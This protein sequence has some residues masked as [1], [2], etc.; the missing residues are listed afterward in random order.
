MI[1][2]IV[3]CTPLKGWSQIT[4]FSVELDTL[5][6]PDDMSDFPELSTYGVYRIYADLTNPNDYL[7][8]ISNINE[9]EVGT[10][11]LTSEGTFFQDANGADFGNDINPLFYAAFPT[12]E[13]DSWWTI[14]MEPG[15]AGDVGFVMDPAITPLADWNTGNDFVVNT[16][17][18]GSMY[19]TS[20]VEYQVE[21][22]SLTGDTL[23]SYPLVVGPLSGMGGDNL[24]VL[25]AQVTVN[26]SFTF[27]ACAQ[28]FPMGIQ[29]NEQ[30]FCPDAILVEHPYANGD[31]VNDADGD[32]VCDEF[33]TLGCT[34]ETACNYDPTA[35]QED[36]SC[37]Y[38]EAPYDCDGNCVNDADGDGICDELEVPGCTGPDACNYD[39]LATDDDE[40]C[41][42]PG[43]A[44]DDGFDLTEGDV[45]DDNCAC[46][47]YSC[48]D[49]NACNYSLEGIEDATLCSYLTPYTISGSATPY[50]QTLQVYTYTATAGSTYEWTVVGGDILDGEGTNE[51]SVTWNT[52]GEGSICVTETNSD[53]CSGEEVCLDVDVT[54]SSVNDMLDG[55][56][57][58]F[59]VPA[60]ENLHLIWTGPTLDNA[61]VTLRDAAG[62]IVMEA[63]VGERDV[64]DVGNLSGGSYML[65]FTVPARGSIQRRILIQ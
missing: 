4:G 13:Y 49:E 32:G 26:H 45:V 34:D 22:D 47:G 28:V 41:V 7:S 54:Q 62:R 14:G 65:E 48:Y 35:S 10:W 3:A 55:T 16:F 29:A 38:A 23:N 46:L 64:L 51:L 27:E 8:A 11:S 6:H 57:D 52:P 60:V 39:P 56:L 30:Q 21:L 43:D 20:E 9:T 31:C 18:G 19:V 1:A 12:I 42:F 33:E 61:F 2:L 15:D 36:D 5:F 25:V 17:I 59:P 24:K 53:G 44:C 50:S 63:P 58:I 37:E 40:S